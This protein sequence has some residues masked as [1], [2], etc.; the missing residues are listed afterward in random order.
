[1]THVISGMI[2]NPVFDRYKKKGIRLQELLE[3]AD[4]SGPSGMSPLGGYYHELAQ[5]VREEARA[6]QCLSFGEPDK[7]EK[8]RLTYSVRFSSQSLVEEQALLVMHKVRGCD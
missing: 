1:M 8:S 7:T 6:Q 4:K 5:L 2:L 3:L